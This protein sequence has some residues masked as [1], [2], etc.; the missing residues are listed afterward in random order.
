M[1]KKETHSTTSPQQAPAA[2][3]EPQEVATTTSE[4]YLV[5]PA[6][7]RTLDEMLA[8]DA[9]AGMQGMGANDFAIP[10]V[11]ILQKGSPQVSRAN[12]KY[13]KDAKP[14]DIYNTVTQEAHDGVEGVLYIPCGYTKSSVEWKPRDSGGGLVAHH[15]EGD[16]FLKKCVRNDRG[17]LVVPDSGNI[18]VDTAYHFGLL[19]HGDALP[20]W[21]VISMYSTQLKKSRMWNTTMRRIMVKGPSGAFNP[22]S[23]SHQYRLTT[24]GE[25]RDTYD[26][27]GWKIVSE[28]R[29]E[30]I[31]VYKMAREFSKQ[32]ED[33]NVRIS[34][35]PQE[36]E[37]DSEEVPF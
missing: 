4:T 12:A 25:T 3:Q 20:E 23:Y 22:P 21:A 28:G 9:G 14:G 29:V 7:S 35:P 8:E 24:A 33:G 1:A 15:K 11:S 13:V 16:P 36:F 5:K 30:D 26:W 27:F 17:Q 34:A 19:L 6:D 10:F 18:I 32:V 31:D 2:A 37:G